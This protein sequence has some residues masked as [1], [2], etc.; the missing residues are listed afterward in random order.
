MT[1]LLQDLRLAL[2]GLAKAPVFTSVAVLSLALG[3]G[4]NT[5]IFSLLDQLLLR[6]LP[7]KNPNEIVQLAARGRHYG[8]NWGMDAMSYP[9]YRDF[10]DKGEGLNGVIARKGWESSLG[11]AGQV[12][13]VRVEIVSGNYFQMLGVSA[14]AGRLFT[15]DDDLKPLAS[16]IVA[17]GYDYWKSRFAGNAGVIGQNLVVGNHNY[18]VVGIVEPGFTGV[19][20]G[21]A[22]QVYIPIA[23]QAQLIPRDKDILEDRRQRWVNVF[24]R[25][26]PGFTAVKA[27]AAAE[28]LYRQI[29]EDEVKQKE[30]AKAD[31]ES[32]DNFLKSRMTVFPGGT[33]TSYLRREFGTALW[34]LMALVGMVL[35]IAC[36][37][38]A[39]LQLAR[40]TARQKEVAV[41][42]SVGARRSQIVRQLL[43]ESL[44][45]SVAAGLLG[46]AIGRIST[47]VLLSLL[48]T[49]DTQLNITSKLD[50][51]VLVFTFLISVLTGV[52]FGLAPALQSTRPDLASTLKDQAGAVVGGTHSAFR[53]A[54]VAVQ[55]TLSLVLLAGAGLFVN[56]LH[57]LRTLNPGFRATRLMMFGINPQANGYSIDRMKS[58]YRQVDEQIATLPGVETVSSGNM[59]IVSGDEWDSSVT[60]E[61]H[62]ASQGS[63]AWAYQNHVLPG[64]F[65]TLGVDFVAGRDFR[66][67]D[68]LKST[69]V[70]IVNEQF[71][72]EYFPGQDPI[73]RHVGMGSDP[74]TKTDI[75][76]IG[77]VK[78]FKYQKMDEKAGRQMYRPYLQMDFAL[79]QWFY[80]RTSGDPQALY[81]AIRG[82][83]HHLDSN[84]PIYGM[85]T[86]EEQVER[87]L[88]TPRLVA[89]LSLCFGVLATLLAVLGLYGVMSYLVGRRRREIGIRMA[90]GSDSSR[91]VRMILK[92]VALLVGVGLGAGLI[93]AVSL[94]RLVTSQL[95]GISPYDPNVLVL[96]T[97][98]LATV[99]LAAGWLPANRASQADP[100][101]TL[102]YE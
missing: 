24:A 48:L 100:L 9:M 1:T 3:I 98:L 17:L 4:A 62:D 53:K 93:A 33:G 73:G 90:L 38:V 47:S 101:R 29:I 49:N 12:E 96:A 46:L 40:A 56:S 51:R 71:V 7:I 23:M 22:A 83:I 55:V 15:Q 72:Q 20:L 25:L 58:F 45:L 41:R 57:N 11:Y 19:E 50:P 69:P 85:R 52:L 75:E 64:Y 84:L 87:N 32:K 70:T 60:I 63:K 78:T 95:Y 97:L 14:A 61:G 91:V 21:S 102:R 5:A 54:L 2:R 37:N 26:K 99:A 34:M 67:S 43:V 16:P 68:T 86:V 42:L 88:A 92:E 89:G 74:G 59:A 13:K 35:L 81:S 31:Q 10:R 27:Q 76:I 18:T 28:P 65:H 66:W 80:V 8:S 82:E 36:A 77:V 79:D 39:N 94:S 44:L 6:M 30:F